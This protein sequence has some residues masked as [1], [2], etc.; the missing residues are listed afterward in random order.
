MASIGPWL[1]KKGA[2]YAGIIGFGFGALLI[3][4]NCVP[5]A[6][7]TTETTSIP[8]WNIAYLVCFPMIFFILW[9]VSTQ[10]YL[11]TGKGTRIGLAYD[12]HNVNVLDWKR[13][14]STLKDLIKNKHIKTQVTLRFVPA[15]SILTEEYSK[16]YRK[17]Y[18]FAILIT[19][20]QSN[21]VNIK[22]SRCKI[23]IVT[24]K[25]EIKFFQKIL[26]RGFSITRKFDST[27]GDLL[28]AQ[29]HTLHDVL[30]LFVA[31]HCYLE[32][33]YKDASAISRHLDKSLSSV[34]GPSQEPR[35][36]T[37]L[38]DINASLRPTDFSV[39][40]MPNPDE[41][42]SI[43]DFAETA[44]CYFDDSPLVAIAV[45]RMRFLLDDIDGAIEL[46]ERLK[47]KIDQILEAGQTPSSRVLPVYFLNYAF[48]S[49]I[50]GN[51]DRAY[52]GY[53][54]MLSVDSYRNENWP[55]I[56]NFIDYVADLEQ[57]DG[58]SYLQTLYRLIANKVVP[59]E[60]RVSAENWVNQEQSR[61]DLRTLLLRRHPT[62]DIQT[63]TE[64]IGPPKKER[65]T[66]QR[67]KRK[68][69]GRKKR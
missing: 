13:T 62:I 21:P 16:K 9:F 51:W 31:M 60:L 48:L 12:G 27:L 65:K 4:L 58:I 61:K 20:R 37:R 53:N 17:G 3:T 36:Q 28:N 29:A 59:T 68:P 19:V 50:H 40:E 67:S 30:L 49:F 24:K 55:E 46:T 14:R 47:N 18:H 26:P 22:N 35:A 23:E 1:S 15:K 2:L 33:Q 32:K 63:Q 64:S 44:M 7:N 39:K 34:M 45:S 42:V 38:L 11:R 25:E 10:V 52:D 69:K 57:Y 56:I 54:N 43:R 5:S 41:L 8:F 66:K 6:P